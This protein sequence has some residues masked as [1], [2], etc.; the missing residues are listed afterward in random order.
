M[1]QYIYKCI[2]YN[3]LFSKYTFSFAFEYTSFKHRNIF[4]HII[5]YK[6]IITKKIQNCIIDS[7]FTG[8]HEN[9]MVA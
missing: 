2:F 7:F 9:K 3:L 5:F 1:N 4:P 6:Q 8:K